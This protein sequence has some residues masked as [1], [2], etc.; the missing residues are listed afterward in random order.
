MENNRVNN[1]G[2]KEETLLESLWDMVKTFVICLVLVTVFV[3]FVAR[4]IRVQ[5]Q[6]MFPTLETGALGF[7]NVYERKFGKLERFD[8]AIIYL[9][10]KKE[11]LVKR[12]I[13]MPGETVSYQNGTLYIDDREVKE[14]FLNTDYRR[15]WQGVFM[16]DV[17]P[18][19]LGENEYY[20]L[21]DNRPASRDSR[22]YGPFQKDQIIAIG[23]FIFF[24]FDQFGV[25]SW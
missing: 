14:S 18:L 24:P 23:A 3:N 5:G 6:S 15:Q 1:K 21:G 9:E 12:I 11:Y 22:Y 16:D 7:A 2:E 8:I 25:K 17:E 20:C 4:P 13:G 10:D 19:T